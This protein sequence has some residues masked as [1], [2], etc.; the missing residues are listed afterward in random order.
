M[1]E[2]MNRNEPAEHDDDVIAML[3]EMLEEAGDE[4]HASASVFINRS[5]NDAYGTAFVLHIEERFENGVSPEE[6]MRR[7]PS[8][9]K[10]IYE[11]FRKEIRFADQRRLIAR[12]RMAFHE[13][14]EAELEHCLE[15][16]EALA[17]AVYDD[18]YGRETG[19]GY[20]RPGVGGSQRP[21]RRTNRVSEWE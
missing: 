5:D 9:A 4:Q 16:S 11:Y 1:F 7:W 19:Y 3:Q 2:G 6:L 15:E 8:W 14:D 12:I 13:R 20:D 17:R 10:F 18:V 21:R